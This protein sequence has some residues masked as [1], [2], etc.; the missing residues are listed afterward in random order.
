M[1]GVWTNRPYA[2]PDIEILPSTECRCLP[3]ETGNRKLETPI[4]AEADG[5]LLGTLP[6]SLSMSDK[7]VNLLVP[8]TAAAKSAVL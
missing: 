5:E 8:R 4:Y 6:V 1:M 2:S 3:L 7:T